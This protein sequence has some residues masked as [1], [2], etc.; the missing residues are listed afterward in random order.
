MRKTASGPTPARATKA[1]SPIPSCASNMIPK[2][3]PPTPARAFARLNQP[4]IYATSDR[5]PGAVPRLSRRAARASRPR[6][7]GR[8]SRSAARPAKS[9]TPT[10]STAATSTSAASPTAELSRWFPSTELVHI[11]DEIADGAWD[12]ARSTRRAPAGPVRRARAPISAW[13]GCKHYTGTPAEHF[14]RFV[15]FTNYVRYVDEFVRFAVDELREPDSR[16]TRP[17]G[18]RRRLSSTATLTDAEAQ[19][20]AGVLAPAP[21]AGL[22]SDRAETATASPWSTS[23]SARPTPRRSATISRCCGPKSG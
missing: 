4:G 10:C 6:L 15:L 9:P 23:A 14:Q 12:H 11:G 21:D 2:C 8:R 17:V 1:P 3:P 7:S 16:F 19:I 13:R 5:P 18:A 20:A 22:S